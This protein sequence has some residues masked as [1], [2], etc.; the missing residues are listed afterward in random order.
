VQCNNENERG[1]AAVQTNLRTGQFE[2]GIEEGMLETYWCIRI[3]TLD[4]SGLGGKGKKI[5][6]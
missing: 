5:P 1:K 2:E 3:A 4:G 6:T